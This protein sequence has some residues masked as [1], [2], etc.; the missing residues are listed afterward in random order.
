MVI[1]EILFAEEHDDEDD[2]GDDYYDVPRRRH[3]QHV[4][5]DDKRRWEAGMRTEIPEFYGTLNQKNSLIGWP[6]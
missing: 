6:R 1:R 5:V 4:K 2:Y 3:R